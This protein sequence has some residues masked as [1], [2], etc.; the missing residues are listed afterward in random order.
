MKRQKNQ[1]PPI[2]RIFL[3]QHFDID[4]SMHSDEFW[5]IYRFLKRFEINYDED[6]LLMLE[7]SPD[8]L[9]TMLIEFID[10]YHHFLQKKI[11]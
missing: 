6:V 4:V 10:E 11:Q 8:A 3:D 2:Q 9:I 7:S 1:N 5:F